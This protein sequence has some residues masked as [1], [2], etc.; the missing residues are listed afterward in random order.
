MSK[1]SV[2]I[3]DTLALKRLAE[4]KPNILTLYRKLYQEK[5]VLLA[6]SQLKGSKILKIDLWNEIVEYQRNMLNF[7]DKRN[8][9]VY[10]VEISKILCTKAKPN[11]NAIIIN[12]DIRQLPFATESLDYILDLSTIDH[13]PEN[14]LTT[15]INEYH[16]CLTPNGI[17]LLIITYRSWLCRIRKCEENERSVSYFFWLKDI[18]QTIAKFKLL[19]ECYISML[20]ITPLLPRLY[21]LFPM[22]LRLHIWLEFNMPFPPVNQQYLAIVQKRT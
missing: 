14:Q 15:I 20:Q 5:A 8:L 18:R 1:N 3:W 6:L 4:L 13:L 21:T 7:L 22:L 17:L 10:T 9:D 19:K 16:R 11:H 12:G 2:H